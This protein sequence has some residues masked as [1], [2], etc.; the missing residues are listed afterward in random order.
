M[1]KEATLKAAELKEA[2]ISKAKPNAPARVGAGWAPLRK[3][4]ER[5]ISAISLLARGRGPFLSNS[6]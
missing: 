4:G 3:I 6:F 5:I 1:L 2:R